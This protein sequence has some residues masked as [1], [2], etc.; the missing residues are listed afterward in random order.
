MVVIINCSNEKEKEKGK[1]KKS[2]FFYKTLALR[3]GK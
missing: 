3:F 2:Y 1:K